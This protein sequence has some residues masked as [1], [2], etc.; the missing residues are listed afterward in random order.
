MDLADFLLARIEE[1]EGFARDA[2]DDGHDWRVE[3][4]TI[5]LWPEDREPADGHLAFPR[6][7]HARHATMWSPVRVLQECAAKRFIVE[8]YLAA[9]NA[10]RTGWDVRRPRDYPLRALAVAYA[11]H[12]DYQ[13]E[14]RL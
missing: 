3:E 9:L 4:S 7:V 2:V 8:D 5:R 11:D 13:P 10:H 14:W 1:D 12:P 6:A